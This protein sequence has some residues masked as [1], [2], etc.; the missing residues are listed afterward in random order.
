MKLFLVIFATNFHSFST[1]VVNNTHAHTPD[2][3]AALV[4]HILHLS[5]TDHALPQDSAYISFLP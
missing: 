3:H 5:S 4:T 2:M 1:E